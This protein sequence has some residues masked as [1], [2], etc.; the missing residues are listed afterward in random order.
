MATLVE[1]R[2]EATNEMLQ[3]ADTVTRTLF[4]ASK[5]LGVVMIAISYLV[6]IIE[7]Q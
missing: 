6:E 1:N 4:D 5:S 3:R 7:E 2:I